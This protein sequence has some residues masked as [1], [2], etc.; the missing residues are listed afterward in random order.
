MHKEKMRKAFIFKE[1]EKKQYENNTEDPES[2]AKNKNR[3]AFENM[4]AQRKI[5][6]S[7]NFISQRKN[8]SS[9]VQNELQYFKLK[10]DFKLDDLRKKYLFLAK[11]YHPDS[12]KND[13]YTSENFNVL[14]NNYEKLKVYYD[15]R[16][17]L[18]EMEN[19]IEED[20]TIITERQSFEWPDEI[21]QPEKQEIIKELS[22]F[23]IFK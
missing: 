3:K 6:Q 12:V 23:L 5:N 21:Y 17:K 8:L 20:G 18:I 22:N 10:D 2:E 16:E 4:Q 13:V 19:N 14:R 1:E 7:R 9:N 11:L 15:I